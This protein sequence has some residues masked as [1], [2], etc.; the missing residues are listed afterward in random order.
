M[1]KIDLAD[2]K[3]RREIPTDYRETEN[4]VREAFWNQFEPGCVEHYL[5][6]VMRD[7]PDFIPELDVV[8][9]YKGKIIG[10]IAYMRNKVV[11][12]DG[13]EYPVIGIGPICVTTEYEGNGI[14]GK[15][16]SYT[17]EIA[18]KMG[19]SAILLQ[20]DPDYYSLK[21]FVPSKQYGIRTFDNKYAAAQQINV[22]SEDDMKDISGRY[23]ESDVYFF[24][25][26]KVEA[27]DE[28]FPKKEKIKGIRLQNKILEIVKMVEPYE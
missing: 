28:G 11:A 14:G 6:H 22:I 10:Q 16:I 26:E 27:F 4:V 3:L 8:A 17:K 12:D 18:K 23:V 7:D 1:T 13:T 15:M 24:D 5:M 25:K 2:V 21:G 20:G 19:F 9:V